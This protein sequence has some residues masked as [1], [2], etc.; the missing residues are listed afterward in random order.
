MKKIL[1][2]LALL[3]ISG[4]LFIVLKVETTEDKL[5][6]IGYNKEQIKIIKNKL[7]DE[8]IEYLLTISYNESY[9]EMMENENFDSEKLTN[10]IDYQKNNQSSINDTILLVNN[11]ITVD[12]NEKLADLISEKYYKKDNFDRYYFNLFF[13]IS[14]I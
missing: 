9:I 10:Y 3:L 5:L 2:F 8:N 13:I 11:N 4:G 1:L 7:T 12:Y 6:N 14:Y